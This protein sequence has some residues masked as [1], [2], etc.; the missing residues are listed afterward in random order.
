MNLDIYHVDAFTDR[1]FSGN[2]A[3]VCIM[4]GPADEGW[5]QGL[6][7]E[8]NL[9]ETAFLYREDEGFRLRWFT[10]ATEVRLCGHA[11]LA[12]AHVLWEAGYMAP[13]ETAVFHT[14]SGKLTARKDGGLL[15]IDLP[16]DP[17]A[18]TEAP[19]A[20][21]DAFGVEL[22]YVGKGDFGY[23][24]EV[25]SE[26]AVRDLR[27][28]FALLRTIPVTGMM[29]TSAASSP[30]Y[31]Y[32]ARAFAPGSGIDEDPVTGAAHCCMGVYW[33]KKLG[34]PGLRAYQASKRGGIVSVRI[35][36]ERAILT[37]AAVTVLKGQLYV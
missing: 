32:V 14:L 4:T 13:G 8:M 28:D 6:A 24:V 10:P 5:M 22:L 31:D 30:G 2:P 11:T 3:A 19:K 25:G 7:A 15:S 26:D 34:R 29:V 36:G 16:A 35:E 21:V 1:P 12:S 17:P 18:E 20:L 37:G 33:T 9:S 23:M 27:P